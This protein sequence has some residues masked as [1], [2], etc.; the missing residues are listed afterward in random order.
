MLLWNHISDPFS[1]NFSKC[2]GRNVGTF[3]FPSCS[4]FWFCVLDFKDAEQLDIFLS[5][6]SYRKGDWLGAVPWGGARYTC[7]AAVI[8]LSPLILRF[9]SEIQLLILSWAFVVPF[10]YRNLPWSHFR[11]SW[12]SWREQSMSKLQWDVYKQNYVN[13]LCWSSRELGYSTVMELGKW[14]LGMQH[15]WQHYMLSSIYQNLFKL[16]HK[17]DVTLTA[18]LLLLL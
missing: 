14:Q 13:C 6:L 17:T 8:T 4:D 18:S 16:C 10:T 2:C 9:C 7:S 15:G 11:G 3:L 1:S 5:C 12:P